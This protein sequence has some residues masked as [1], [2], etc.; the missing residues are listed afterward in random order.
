MKRRIP[1][2][3]LSSIAKTFPPR[4]SDMIAIICCNRSLPKKEIGEKKQNKANQEIY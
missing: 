4:C 3:Y 2:Q 1:I